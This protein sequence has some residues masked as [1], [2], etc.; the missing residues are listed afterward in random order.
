MYDLL[1]ESKAYHKPVTVNIYDLLDC[2]EGS[3]D[4]GTNDDWITEMFID[5]LNDIST[6]V[7]LLPSILHNGLQ[8]P[9]NVVYD[10]GQFKM[11]NGHHRLV[12]ALL[13]GIEE[14][15]VI[16]S[17]QSCDFKN[18]EIEDKEQDSWIDYDSDAQIF[19]EILE[20][21]NYSRIPDDDDDDYE[22]DEPIEVELTYNNTHCMCLPCRNYRAAQ[23]EQ[24]LA[25][26]QHKE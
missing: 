9:L 19:Y 18:S 26:A 15:Q 6:M 14:I 3:V 16:V 12:L 23:I 7:W 20:N 10:Y 11:G 5:K 2:L 21:V 25:N 8:C 17:T 13:C 24:E 22:D 1:F 4:V